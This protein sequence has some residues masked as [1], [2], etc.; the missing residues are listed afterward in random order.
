MAAARKAE[1]EKAIIKN[2]TKKEKKNLLEQYKEFFH[3]MWAFQ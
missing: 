3:G 1:A 2:D